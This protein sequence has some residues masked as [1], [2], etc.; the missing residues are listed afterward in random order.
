[1]LVLVSG[2]QAAVDAVG[3]SGVIPGAP[4]LS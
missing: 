4:R 3:A 2:E 1:M